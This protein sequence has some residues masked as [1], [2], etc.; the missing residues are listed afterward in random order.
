MKPNDAAPQRILVWFLISVGL[1]VATSQIPASLADTAG[2]TVAEEPAPARPDVSAPKTGVTPAADDMTVWQLFRAGG[3]LMWPIVALSIVAVAF[4]VE[5]LLGL[6]RRK[7]LPSEL[8]RGLARLSSQKGGFDPRQAYKLCQQHPS[9]AANVVKA[10][11][12][13]I[14]RPN[15]ELEQAVT[16]A[17]EREAARLY[18][19]VRW[20]NLAF[21]VAPMLGLLGTV[22]GMILVFM[23][24]VKTAGPEKAEVMA[25]GIYMKLVC[26]FGGLSVAIPA[27]ICSHLFEGR[28]L[29]MM[30]EVE[31]AVLGL[32]PQL[33]R[34]EGRVRV[35]R[36]Q[37]DQSE[38]EPARAAPA[39]D[40]PGQ[41]PAA[42]PK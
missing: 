30:S 13:K 1:V 19:N 3:P 25:K 7:I 12:L 5:R 28:I 36:S 40:V 9:A 23:D 35:S 15:A 10:L 17:N 42:A 32:L 38:A 34:F 24:A 41:Q 20:L 26:T 21:T 16:E 6:R 27:V 14:G 11:L 31:D 22:Q 18:H 33:E 4:A 29:R 37:L 2:Q 39:E 8:V